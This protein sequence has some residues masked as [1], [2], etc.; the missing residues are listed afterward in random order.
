MVLGA[1]LGDLN[2]AEFMN[3]EDLERNYF[4]LD[5]LKLVKYMNY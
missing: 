5:D 4:P 2:L 1:A 3:H